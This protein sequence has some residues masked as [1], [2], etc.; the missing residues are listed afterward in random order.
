MS[1]ERSL[2]EFVVDR[3]ASADRVVGWTDI[4]VHWASLGAVIVLA[5]LAVV[6]LVALVLQ[7]P[8]LLS[9]EPAAALEKLFGGILLLFILLELYQIGGLYFR[10][11]QVIDKVFEVGLVALVRQL[12]VSEFLHYTVQQ[13]VAIATL[14]V[15]LGAS[16][17]LARRARPGIVPD[18]SEPPDS[19]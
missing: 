7:L 9:G 1:D 8:S 13:L 18:D 19:P 2:R 16:W 3:G 14:V 6:G 11:E 10:R 15:A 4:A 5:L 17:Y 12:I